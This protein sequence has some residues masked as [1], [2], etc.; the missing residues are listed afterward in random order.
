MDQKTK[1]VVVV[2]ETASGKSTLALQL[3][4]LFSG[5]LICADSATTRREMNIGTAKPTAAEQA[6]VA[7]HLLDMVGPND[8]FSVAQFKQQADQAIAD[9]AARG[10]LPI[11]V[12]GTGL[13]VDSVLYDYQF[14]EPADPVGREKLNSMSLQK[15]Q[16]LAQDHGLDT[17]VIDIHNPHRLIRLIETKGQPAEKSSL[18]A[19]TLVLGLQPDREQLLDRITKRVDAMLDAGLETEVQNLESRYGWN[20]HGLK[21]IGYSEWQ[22]YFLGNINLAE[23]RLKIIKDTK[24]LAKRQR[25]WFRRNKSIQWLSTP[26]VLD[27]VVASVTTFLAT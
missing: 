11:V 6:L 13:Y 2:G 25:T 18:R 26:V 23:T 21:N 10:K 3:A 17:S 4:Q 22:D 27:D 7:H 14:R 24:D 1:L 20:A 16:Q 8:E 5:E 15:L 19:N 12:G 9:I